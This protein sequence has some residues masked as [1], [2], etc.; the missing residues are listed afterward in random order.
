MPR[1]VFLTAGEQRSEL[2]W[3]ISR[4]RWPAI[5]LS[6]L[7]ISLTRPAPVL[8]AA[9]YLVTAIAALVN[10]GI[11]FN[12]RAH[13]RW[14]D[15]LAVLSVVIDFIF[16]AVW[17]ACTANDPTASNYVIYVVVAIEVAAFFYWPGIWIFVVALLVAFSLTYV[18]KSV[19][20]HE[21][22]AP[23]SIVFRFSV[24][25][26]VATLAGSITSGGEARRASAEAAALEAQRESARL[27]MVH[28]LARGLGASLQRDDVL[29]SVVS[30]LRA[31]F[32]ARWSGVLL[33]DVAGM[34]RLVAANGNPSEL[35]IPLPPE[36]N[37]P[38]VEV[39]L[40]LDNFWRSAQL[41]RMGIVPPE[42]LRDYTTA[43]IVPLHV[44]GRRLGG[45]VTLSHA[46]DRIDDEDVKLLEAV[47]PQVSTALE[48]ARL[49][50]ETANLALTDPLTGL[51]NRRAFEMRLEEEIQRSRR[52]GR[53]L[54]LVVLD[55]DHFKVYNDTHGHQAGD[56][57]LRRLGSALAERLLR[58][59]D[60]AF[61]QG[62]EEFAVIMPETNAAQAEDV[63]RRVHHLLAFEPLPLGDHQ[64][65]G[66]LTISAGVSYC[67][68]EDAVGSEL[69][70]QAD[71]A[72]FGAKQTGRNRTVVY[73]STLSESL[74]NWTKELPRILEAR[75]IHAVYQPIVRLD[76]GSIVAYEALARPDAA[77][78]VNGVASATR[79]SRRR[80]HLRP[81][82]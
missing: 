25:I 75:S 65:G 44:G 4:F 1:S 78:A 56:D 27:E 54:S 60:L 14:V 10:L 33:N 17:V 67:D 58:V 72:L 42:S 63:M 34:A 74:T 2:L 13:E 30:A 70:E 79:V 73:D 64:P 80:G 19:V 46:N 11:E 8:P 66:H 41:D 12:R 6:L 68:A 28:R 36:E 3:R 47:A 50:E 59:T 7:L 61:R 39:T 81:P 52:H 57:I 82:L 53:A 51:G 69:F 29:E 15:L 76:D 5:G 71:L 24:L 32:P 22:L 55:I 16:C 38:P 45:L 20:L 77:E 48:N 62:G 18:E 9:L 37:L 43:V 40:H 23:G 26:V 35:V 31:L 21:T 49:Y